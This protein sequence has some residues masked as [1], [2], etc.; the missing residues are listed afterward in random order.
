MRRLGLLLSLVLVARAGDDSAA[1]LLRIYDIADLRTD[2]AWWAAAMARVKAAAP[3]IDVRQEKG[4]LVVAATAAEHEKIAKELSA[5]REAFDVLVTFDVRLAKIDGGAGVTS[6]PAEKL[7]AFLKEKHADSRAGPCLTCRNGQQ[8]SIRVIRQVSYIS[9]FRVGAD[10]E[11]NVVADPVVSLLDDGVTASLRPLA[12]RDAI[13]VAVDAS[14]NEVGEI[15]EVELPFPLPAPV[16]IQVPERS[17]WSVARLVECK[18][19]AWSVVD[20]GSGRVLFLRATR[21]ASGDPGK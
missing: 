11:G 21:S 20:L 15:R 6:V 9:D 8:A 2:E 12:T 13:R 3:G 1:P 4:C 19:D 5:V 17:T 10:D 16:K 18:P 7:D 14:V